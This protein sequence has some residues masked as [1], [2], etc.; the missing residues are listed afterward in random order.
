MDLSSISKAIA[1]GVV[2]LIVALVARYGFQA[3]AP[4]ISAIGVIVT[5]IVGYGV[6]HI[7]VFLAPA[8]TS[9]V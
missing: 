3:D 7:A 8:N 9:K 1:G 5:A 4:T 2:G 6:G